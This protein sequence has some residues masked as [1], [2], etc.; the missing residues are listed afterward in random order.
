MSLG[1]LCCLC[2][3]Q[4]TYMISRK[5]NK[6]GAPVAFRDQNASS[7]KDAYIECA[8][9][10]DKNYTL[11]QVEKDIGLQVIPEVKGTST[12]TKW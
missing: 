8:S 10:V 12:Q 9:Y 4:V 6:F 11:T 5:R 1:F 3:F 2:V 7:V